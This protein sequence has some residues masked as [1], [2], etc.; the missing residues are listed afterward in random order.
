MYT[1]GQ[2]SSMFH[3]PVST[4]RYYDKE[5]LFPNMERRSGIRAFSEK[6]VEALHMIE[7]LKKTGMEIRD[8]KEFMLWCQQGP[9]TYEK[10]RNMLLQQKKAVE[11]EI[12]RM[13]QVL[14]M[15]TYK[16]WYY[17]QAIADGNE[18][19]LQ[20]MTLDKMPENIRHAYENGHK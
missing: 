9:A 4:L 18:E 1:I 7:C 19:R 14:D 15:V 11:A 10:R 5:G 12:R 3:L 8:I 13:N 16:C 17:E 2:I 6:E 20:S